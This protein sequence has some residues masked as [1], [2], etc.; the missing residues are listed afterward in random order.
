[1]IEVL[2]VDDE[3]AHRLMVRRA[4]LKATLDM[5]VVEA[6]SVHGGRSAFDA[7]GIG[8]MIVDLNLAGSSGLELIRHV[9]ASPDGAAIPLI[10]I[11]TSTLERDVYAAY[12]EGANTFIFKSAP[13]SDF[14][15]DLVAAVDFL[16]R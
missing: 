15:R 5:T 1:M 8:L 6:E 10:V 7:G 14:V 3:V 2:V 11:S 12:A 13:G 9:R 16:T 4:L